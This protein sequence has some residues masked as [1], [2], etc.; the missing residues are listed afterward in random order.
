MTRLNIWTALCL[1]L[2][3]VATLMSGMSMAQNPTSQDQ[4]A[5]GEK[6]FEGL[7]MDIDNNAHVLTLKEGDMEMRFSFT[8]Q[9]EVVVPDKDKPTVVAQGTKMRVHYTEQE[10]INIATKIEIIATTA[11]R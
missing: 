6:V 10:K 8:D 2:V 11:A 1:G 3:L 5:E 9:T 4:K 7:L